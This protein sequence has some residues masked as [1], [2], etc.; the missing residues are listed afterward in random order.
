LKGVAFQL[1]DK[2]PQRFRLFSCGY[3]A[4]A[5]TGSLCCVAARPHG[6]GTASRDWSMGP[7]E[8]FWRANTSFSPPLSRR[9]DYRLHSEGFSSFGSQ[10]E[11]GGPNYSSSMSSNKGSS[12][13]RV[14]LL[15]THPYSASD[16]GASDF[17]SPNDS[18]QRRQLM[19][20]LVQGA[21]NEEFVR[22]L[23][24]EP[25]AF[26]TLVEG[27]SGLPYSGGSTSSRSDG[28]V[29]YELPL[30]A[31]RHN[32]LNRRS[33]ISK[34]VHPLSFP[35]HS[36]AS[37]NAT[38]NSDWKQNQ[39]CKELWSPN[40]Q[41]ES[42]QFSSTS[43]IDLTDASESLESIFLSPSRMNSK[44]GSTKCGLCERILSKRSPWGSRRI[45]RSGDMPTTSIL[46]CGHVYHAECL[47][48]TTP[49]T[50]KHDPP[51]P[52]CEK[53]LGNFYEQWAV[54]RLKNGLPR[55]RSLGEE[56]P[57]RVWSCA[58][59]G[60]CVEGALHGPK[61]NSMLV[62][63]RNRLK[64]HLILKGNSGKDRAESSKGSGACSP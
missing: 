18:F 25:L 24:F 14:E 43:S 54:C 55:L 64:R 28:S 4:V 51:C 56:G 11:D 59:V 19:Q 5:K 27:T 40:T 3:K 12:W 33:F 13:E 32:T 23:S 38:Q 1:F 35:D 48:R 45:V 39:T 31:L 47:E 10:G 58:Q 37:S 30:K 44:Y 2:L 63:S 7:S 50:H 29:E 20:S 42:L 22:E 62:L 9:W 21:N 17:S 26:S 41:T 16:G 15:P 52:L 8:P 57:S 6:P 36:I 60:D 49:K 53:S 34:P 61:S 46:S